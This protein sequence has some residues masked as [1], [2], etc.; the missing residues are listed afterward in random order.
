MELVDFPALI[1]NPHVWVQFPHVLAGGIVTAGF[2]VLGISAYH[3]LKNGFAE[4]VFKESFRF[5]MIY[6][7]IGAILVALV[8]H[9]STTRG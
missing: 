1:F 9:T 6:A 8:G 4:G 2:F 7:L 5:T 3:L